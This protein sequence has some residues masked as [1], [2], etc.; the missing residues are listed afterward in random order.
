[1]PIPDRSAPARDRVLFQLKTRG[2]ATPAVVAERLAI[3]EV[4]V[5]QHLRRLEAEGLVETI[6]ARRGAGRP[7]RV[8]AV[9]AAAAAHFPDTHAELTADLLA[10]V[11]AAF[12]ERG[13]DRVIDTRSAAQRRVYAERLRGARSLGERVERLAAARNAEGYLAEWSRLPDGA[14][15]LIENHCPICIAAQTCQAFC[16]DELAVFREVLGPAVAVE[17]TDHLL[18]GARRCAYRITPRPPAREA[19]RRRGAGAAR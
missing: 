2:P 16:R 9:T 19:R 14:W 18:A 1:M 13:L 12:G 17:R 4:A 11:R 6:E 8:F 10:A 5:R 15:L 7:A 3:S